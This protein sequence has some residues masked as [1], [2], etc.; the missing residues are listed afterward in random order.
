M[1][2]KLILLCGALALTAGCDRG[3]AG[4]GS[5]GGNASA[6][7]EGKAEDGRVTVKAPGVD[8]SVRIPEAV[9]SRM[10]TNS[11]SELVPPGA[12]IGGIHVQG[13]GREGGSGGD[14]TV[15]LSFASDQAPQQL[16]AWYRDP[17][18]GPQFTVGSDI[19]EGAAFVVGGTT[20][21]NGGRFTVRLSPRQGGGTE[22]RLL[23]SDRR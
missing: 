3:A 14:G 13:M 19:R 7:A 4:N 22:G 2:A 8:I 16:A 18:R 20:R 10:A 11:N 21:E 1:K 17:A 15:E 23:L 9:R 6:T 12:R 5:A